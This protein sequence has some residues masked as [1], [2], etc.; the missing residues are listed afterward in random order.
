MFMNHH[1]WEETYTRKRY[2]IWHFT[3]VDDNSTIGS[4]CNIGQNVYIACGIVLGDRVKIQNNVSIYSGVICEDEVFI[5]PSAVFTN[6]SSPRSFISQKNKFKTTVIRKGATIGANATVVC[7]NTI[8]TYAFVGAGAVITSDVPDYAL[9]YG[10]PGRIQGWVCRCG[11]RLDLGAEI[12]LCRHCN[13]LY[14]LTEDNRLV[15]QEYRPP[16]KDQR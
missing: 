8:G 15:F 7:G 10:N 6:V 13:S 4:D 9:V 12:I 5:G 2:E 1:T 11:N 16:L 3:H 14:A